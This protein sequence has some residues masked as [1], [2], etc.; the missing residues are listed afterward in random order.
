[1]AILDALDA[2]AGNQFAAGEDGSRYNALSGV[3]TDDRLYVNTDSAACNVYLGVEANATEIIENTDC[4]GRTPLY[5]T[6]DVSYSVLANGSL[7]D[8]GDGISADLQATHSN[9]VFPFLA[10]PVIMST[11]E[12]PGPM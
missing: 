3:L 2:I 7:G 8:V 5:D 1:M 9:T 10:A 11:I 4:G 6:V 12:E